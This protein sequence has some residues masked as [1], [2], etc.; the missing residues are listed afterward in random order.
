MIKPAND[1][2][3]MEQSKVPKTVLST[4][5]R[6]DNDRTGHYQAVVTTAANKTRT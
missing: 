5:R 1:I 3:E 6:P 2:M 4:N